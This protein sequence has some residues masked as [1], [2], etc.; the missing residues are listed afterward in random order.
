[1]GGGIPVHPVSG[2]LRLSRPFFDYSGCGGSAGRHGL[3][4]LMIHTSPGE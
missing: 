2:H 4:V 3:P 1:M